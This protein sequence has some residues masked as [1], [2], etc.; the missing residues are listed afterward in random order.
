MGYDI[1][2][3]Q[4]YFIHLVTCRITYPGS[5][6]RTIKY[7]YR[8]YKNSVIAQTIYRYLDKIEATLIPIAEEITFNHSI[9]SVVIWVM[10]C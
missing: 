8:H 1:I 3:S 10:R 5:K 2:D 6:L 9:M 4:D 7:L